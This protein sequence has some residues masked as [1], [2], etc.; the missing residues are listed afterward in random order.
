MR[1]QEPFLVA[2]T[3]LLLVAACSPPA[4]P[5]P[6]VQPSTASPTVTEPPPPTASPVATETPPATPTIL[7][8]EILLTAPEPGATVTSPVEVRG[9]VSVMPFEGT[10]RGRVY[11]AQGQVVGEK[12]IQAQ[13]DV[14][15][16]LG[17]P[18]T[19]VGDI[20]FQVESAGPGQVE[21]AEM[22]VRD[23]SIVASASVAVTLTTA[24]SPDLGEMDVR[25]EWNSTS[26]D[27][28]WSA[29][30]LAAFP[31]S[32]EVD[33]YYTRLTV[34]R[35]DG[36]QEWTVVDAWS[37][38]ALGYTT[39]QPL[40]WSSDGRHFYYT[41]RPVPDGCAVFVNGS[42]LQRVDLS[43]GSVTEMVPAVGLWLSLSPDE[44]KLAYVGYGDRGLVLRDLA[45]GDERQTA[46]EAA[47]EA[48]DTHLGHVVW[49]PDGEAL[50]LT[51]A[52]NACGPQEN[53]RHAIVR[54]A[55]GTLSQTSVVPES[56]RL[57]VTAEW[58][59]P[60]RVL[61]EDGN[62]ETWWLNPETGDIAPSG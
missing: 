41:N 52:M 22:S 39:P 38:L 37:E 36:T 56:D 47:E 16:D 27:G 19:F 7:P 50:M 2:L 8:R 31:E 12:P 17:G 40:R 51:V 18:G 44:T 1:M 46:I 62:G 15:G 9:R 53:R 6:T 24:P 11:D 43:D 10:L 49:S 59:E 45:T 21:I 29:R 30:G 3:V 35:S 55:A 33:R 23:G 13:S 34:A 48:E 32:G 61:L 60:H 4:T 58:P 25:D 54:I 26:P 20:P 14:E 28:A 57:F 5:S 42:D